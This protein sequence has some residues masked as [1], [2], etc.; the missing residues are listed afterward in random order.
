MRKV[1]EHSG[2]RWCRPVESHAFIFRAATTKIARRGENFL[3]RPS[4][5]GQA[6]RE[7]RASDGRKQTLNVERLVEEAVRAAP[8]AVLPHLDR[9]IGA[10][11]EDL[12]RGQLA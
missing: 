2:A 3:R 12:R 11:D 5:R 8:H 10:C 4:G 7:G 6:A 1:K 9:G